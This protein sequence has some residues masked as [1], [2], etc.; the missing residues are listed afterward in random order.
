MNRRSFLKLNFKSTVL[1]LNEVIKP[2]IE[3]ERTCHRPPGAGDEL[4]F[5]SLCNGCGECQS[6]CPTGTITLSGLE[7]GMN[8]VNRPYLRLNEYPCNFCGS[9][10]DVCVT[11]A[12][13][14]SRMDD[15]IGRG[16]ILKQY[17]KAYANIMCDYC[18]RA[19]TKVGAMDIKDFCYPVINQE[20]CNGCGFCV[21]A[22]IHNEKGIEIQVIS[23]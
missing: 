4:E 5:L 6:V 21:Q 13:D 7:T 2:H 8:I 20:L 15:A 9:C 14:R 23:T 22:C 19:C 11:H 18:V 12:L 1:F 16:K 3:I 10:I 17:C